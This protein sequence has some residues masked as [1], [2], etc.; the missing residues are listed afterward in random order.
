VGPALAAAPVRVTQMRVGL[1]LNRAWTTFARRPI[2]HI[3]GY[4]VFVTASVMLPFVGTVFRVEA[5]VAGLG[6]LAKNEGL[7]LS[8]IILP[9]KARE[10]YEL[11]F[12]RLVWNVIRTDVTVLV[13]FV[14]V[15]AFFALPAAVL[16]PV[17][18]ALVSGVANVAPLISMGAWL[19]LG[20]VGFATLGALAVAFVTYVRLLARVPATRLSSATH[21]FLIT[22]AVGALRANLGFTLRAVLVPTAIYLGFAL[23]AGGVFALVQWALPLGGPFFVAAIG[24]PAGLAFSAW[25]LAFGF[26]VGETLAATVPEAEVALY[27]GVSLSARFGGFFLDICRGLMSA[28]QTSYLV[29]VTFLAFAALLGLGLL[30]G[31]DQLSGS[32]LGLIAVV[33]ASFT[34]LAALHQRKGGQS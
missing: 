24:L 28:R 3:A 14:F 27:D 26:Q 25:L 16:Y 9:T 11:G 32:F 31:V 20:F 13:L 23:V 21:L 10:S 34:A 15:A 5:F 29:L 1:A 12:W 18:A 4:L 33:A 6:R 8:E 2:E 17:N 30:R 7:V 22:R 19:P